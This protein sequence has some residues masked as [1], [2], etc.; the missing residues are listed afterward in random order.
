MEAVAQAFIAN[1]APSFAGVV[2]R[3]KH[4]QQAFLFSATPACR[5][6]HDENSF[7]VE[8]NSQR[9]K[10]PHRVWPCG[11]RNLGLLTSGRDTECLQVRS[12]FRDANVASD[13]SCVGLRSAVASNQQNS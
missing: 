10:L 5:T 2:L 13:T 11:L 6:Q 7:A 8:V 9:V 1:A 12:E 3:V 4:D